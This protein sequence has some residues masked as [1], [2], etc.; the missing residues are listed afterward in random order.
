MVTNCTA[1][2]TLAKEKEA[3]N[4]RFFAFLK[5]QENSTIDL[6]VKQ[7]NELIAPKIDCTACGNCCKNLLINVE[8]EEIP[9]L[10]NYLQLTESRLKE[11][12]IEEGGHGMLLINTIPCHFLKNNK[13][14]VYEYRFLGCR[15][16]P[17]LEAPQF[18]KRLFTTMMHYGKCPIIFNVV[19]SLKKATNFC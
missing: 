18:T 15:Q 1:I 2:A 17:N 3:E 9:P 12:Y 8:P 4:D 19:E 10:A 6:E 13:C 5:M 14:T 11:K 7:L 16:F